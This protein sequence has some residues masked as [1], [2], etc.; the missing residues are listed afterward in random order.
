MKRYFTLIT[1]VFLTLH[2]FGKTWSAAEITQ[3]RQ[4]DAAN[5]VANPD[6]ILSTSTV[7][8]INTLLDDI[9]RRTNAQVA[10]AVID[11]YDGSDIDDF[12][13][14]LF[15]EWGV[16]E[17]GADN[18]VLLV[19]AKDARQYAFRTGRG[20]GSVLTDLETG[21]IARQYLV[22]AF[23]RGDYDE[24]ILTAMG[25]VHD[26]MTNP[27]AVSE[28][29]EMSQRAK[30]SD[31]QTILDVVI[32]YLWCCV[33]LTA[34]LAFWAF[35]RTKETA[36]HERHHRYVELHPMLRILYGLSFVGLGI[37]FLV[38]YPMKKF[39]HNLR[40]GHHACPN[41][42]TTMVK[43]DEV[44]DNEHLTPAQDAEERYNSVD[45]DVWECPNCGEEDIYAFENTDSDLTECDH[46]HARTA[47]FVR[48]RVLVPPTATREGIAVKEYD[49][50]NCG[51]RTQKKYTLPRTPGG[52]SAAAA[53]APFI[54]GGMGRGGGGFGGGGSF[55]GGFTGGGGS[56]GSW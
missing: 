47:R 52:G 27:E 19:V 9:N 17:R 5:Y 46:C 18:G 42:G 54:F 22:P 23:R 12:A 14:E 2:V 36:K 33:I 16:G 38:Y 11:N 41:C 6:G 8:Q 31:S 45:Y 30:D 39:L 56:S 1:L 32:F 40:D 48:S 13:T 44:H 25:A 37:P 43:I 28:I 29:R 50:L 53:A 51:K 35:W 34:I 24:G 21:Q 4:Y 55:G 26:R 20:I 3:P 10:V 7:S 15:E 49:C